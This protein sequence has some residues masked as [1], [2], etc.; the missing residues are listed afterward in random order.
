MHITAH[1]IYAYQSHSET[2]Y[3]ELRHSDVIKTIIK[4]KNAK[5]HKISNDNIN[6]I[7][8]HVHENFKITNFTSEELSYYYYYIVLV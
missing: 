4:N 5:K 7:N 1:L 2:F 8:Y 3:T 6:S